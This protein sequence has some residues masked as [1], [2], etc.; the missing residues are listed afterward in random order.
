MVAKSPAPIMTSASRDRSTI[1]RAAAASQCTSLKSQSRMGQGPLCPTTA[2]AGSAPGG[3]PG[4]LPYESL[5]IQSVLQH[6][7][8]RPIEEGVGLFMT[9]GIGGD[10]KML[11]DAAVLPAM[12]KNGLNHSTVREVFHDASMLAEVCLHVQAA[13]V[14]VVDLADL[15]SAVMYVLGLCHGLRRCP[16]LLT[17]SVTQLP[18]NLGALRYLEYTPT[19]LGRFDLRERLERALRVF[20]SATQS[21][22]QQREGGE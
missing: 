10:G 5:Q 17:R 16:I 9:P 19:M 12:R 1:R 2:S 14:I 21:G 6:D 20:L 15:N 3:M 22:R 13:Q 11:F 4:V 18:F 8:A 7:P